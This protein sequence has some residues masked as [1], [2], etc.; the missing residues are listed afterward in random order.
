MT[1]ELDKFL[2]SVDEREKIKK[3]EQEQ[4]REKQNAF[5]L[6]FRDCLQK[7]IHPAMRDVLEKLRSRGCYALVLKERRKQSNPLAHIQGFDEPP[8]TIE[9]KFC[10]NHYE[11]Y[12][13][14]ASK[15]VKGLCFVLTVVGNY[16]TQKVCII[17]EYIDTSKNKSQSVKKTEE[18]YA[19]SEITAEL[20]DMLI[21]KNMNEMLA[22]NQSIGE[23]NAS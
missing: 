19:L 8:K 20:F 15:M 9:G 14:S 4:V 23:D 12:F 2:D 5:I 11:N 1:S 18:Q 16:A 17:T 10:Y 7:I 13:I 22:I 3:E 21:V 6:A